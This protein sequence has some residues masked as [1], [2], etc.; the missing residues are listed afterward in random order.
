MR[1]L[2]LIFFLF[3][4]KLST[5][6]LLDPYSDW[7]NMESFFIEEEVKKKKIKSIRLEI[8]NKKDDQTFYDQGEFIEYT[9]NPSGKINQ[10]MKR[11]P[12]SSGFDSSIVFFQYDQAKRLIRKTEEIGPFHFIYEFN[13]STEHNFR[14]WKLR[15]GKHSYDTLYER[16]HEFQFSDL[17]SVEVISN[18]AGRAFMKNYFNYSTKGELEEKGSVYLFNKNEVKTQYFI[19]DGQLVGKHYQKDFGEKKDVIWK[20]RYEGNLLEF[21]EIW[22]KG[23]MIEKLAFTYD[24]NLPKAIILRN[25]Q[26]KYVRIYRCKYETY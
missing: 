14:A 5:G 1:Q 7:F 4:V 17:E 10:I 24:S 20:Y 22:K 9:F 26:E 21:I 18:R 19:E 8:S 25:M 15:P 3:L 16:E 12:I 11:I 6:Q 23:T 2:F 13:Y